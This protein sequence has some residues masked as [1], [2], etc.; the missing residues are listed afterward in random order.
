M[1]QGLKSDKWSESELEWLL[2][3]I[4]KGDITWMSLQLDRSYSAVAQKLHKHRMSSTGR[5]LKEIAINPK[6]Q[7]KVEWSRLPV[8]HPVM[9]GIYP[10]AIKMNARIWRERRRI[11]LK[12]H[13]DQCY[14][15]GDEANTVDHIKPRH[16]G[17][18]DS[19][20]NLVAACQRCNFA[21]VGRVKSW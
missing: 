16:E 7:V 5:L 12:M 19:L 8:F 14:W 17:G 11:I 10:S 9:I 15:C 4:G 2:A 1:G 6:I 21:H 20:D 18:I 13:D 3:N